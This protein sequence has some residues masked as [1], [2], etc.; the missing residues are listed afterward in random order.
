MNGQGEARR[1]FLTAASASLGAMGLASLAGCAQAVAPIA[2]E[3]GPRLKAAVCNAGL[4]ST[5]CAHGM[6]TVQWWGERLGVDVTPYDSQFSIDKQVRD[7]EDMATKEWDFVVIQAYAIDTLEAPIKRLIDQ[8]IPVV[9][10][11]TLLVEDPRAIGLW[12][13]VTPD[14]EGLAAAATEAV[15]ASIGYTGKVVHTQGA[16]SH[17]GAQL[18]AKGFRSVAAKYPD[19]EVIDEQPADWDIAK[20]GALWDDLLVKHAQIDG[21]FIHNDD[22]AMAA[23]QALKRAGGGRRI[24]M[25]SV[26]AQDA[27]IDGVMSGDLVVSAMNPAG[28]VHWLSFMIGYLAATGQKMSEVPEKIVLDSPVVTKENAEQFRYLMRN[29]LI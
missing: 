24:P 21:A 14:H 15:F 26:D 3:G 9:D 4:Q 11:D 13:Y 22:M 23:A 17:S 2:A 8:G 7:V 27:G 16:L 28:R 6:K 1:A 5:W 29:F 19:I 25:A 12:T 20:A 18:R 10:M